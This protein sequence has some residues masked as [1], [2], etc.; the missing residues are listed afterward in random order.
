MKLLHT[1][2]WHLGG[3]L[4]EFGYEQEQQKFLDWL[5]DTMK[6]R[7]FDVLVVSGDVFHYPTPSN[8]AREMYYQFLRD[9]NEQAHPRRVVVVAGNHDSPSGIDAPSTVL[10]AI[11]VDVAGHRPEP[12]SDDH[13]VPIVDS[14]GDPRLVVAAIPYLSEGDL[15]VPVRVDEEAR[16]LHARYTD[17]FEAFYDDVAATGREKYGDL[18][19]VATGHMT[20]FSSGVDA[21][22]EHRGAEIHR[23]GTIGAMPPEVFS[24]DFDYVALGHI[25]SCRAVTDDR[26][27]CYSGTPTPTR[28]TEAE[29]RKVLGV[30]FDEEGLADVEE[31]DVPIWRHILRLSGSSDELKDQ[32][33]SLEVDK[34]LPP[35]LF[36][37]VELAD[38]ESPAQV[39][40]D[41]A[42]LLEERFEDDENRPRIAKCR[43]P[44][45]E[46]DLDEV[47]GDVPDLEAMSPRDVFIE[48]FKQQKSRD[49]DVPDEL[50]EYFDELVEQVDQRRREAN[51]E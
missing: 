39:Q 23:T 51:K 2:D 14:S 35:Y 48:R 40:K 11:D 24:D 6:D 9:C 34:D 50:L 20:C 29:G 46:V 12:G 49:R 5:L 15:G 33:E 8:A 17:A 43:T 41:L 42:D 7:E 47:M 19:L 16:S 22:V 1:S 44:L 30:A 10:S 25:H 27:V 18:P 28:V 3:S 4:G 26:R 37:E 31:I 38:G 32:L 36:I 21:E 13:L 45:S